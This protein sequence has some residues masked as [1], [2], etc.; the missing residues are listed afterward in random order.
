MTTVVSDRYP[1]LAAEHQ[2]AQRLAAWEARLRDVERNTREALVDVN[3]RAL[4]TFHDAWGYFAEDLGFEVVAT[5]EPFPGREPSPAYIA[6]L[7]R[8][9]RA[10][11]LTRIYTEPQLASANIQSLITDLGMELRVLDPLGSEATTTDYIEL[12]RYNA[13]QLR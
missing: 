5:F 2:F 6:E 8:T 4:V 11:N 7:Q 13:L 12:L 9:I 1:L 10:Y 3:Q